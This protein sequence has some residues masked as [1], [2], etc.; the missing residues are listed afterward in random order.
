MSSYFSLDDNLTNTNTVESFSHRLL[1][2]FSGTARIIHQ[3]N[4]R[5]VSNDSVNWRIHIKPNTTSTSENYSLFGLWNRKEGLKK[6]TVNPVQSEKSYQQILDSFIQN[7]PGW[8]DHLSFPLRDTMECWLLDMLHQPLALLFSCQDNRSLSQ[9]RQ[10][11]WLPCALNDHTFISSHLQPT[12][13]QNHHNAAPIF[14]RDL[15]AQQVHQA[16]GQNRKIQWF[17]RQT[18]GSGIGQE[19]YLIDI[20]LS[21]R[22]LSADKFPHYLL[23]QRW[24]NKE[25]QQLIDDF[26]HWQSPW[27]LTLPDLNDNERLQLE[28]QASTYPQRLYALHQLYPKLLQKTLINKTL[29]QAQFERSA[30]TCN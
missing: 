9:I 26:F 29:I 6:L 3:K 8:L 24:D 30:P 4:V 22:Q 17:Q 10:P 12:T 15:V 20:N 16:A 21:G 18:D 7:L 11:T 1:S 28:T 19:H 27:L 25:E 5:A 2:P 14:H 13:H 23:R